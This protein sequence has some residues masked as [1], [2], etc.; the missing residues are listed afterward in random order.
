MRALDT[1][2]SPRLRGGDPDRVLRARLCV[3]AVP[4]A[5]APVVW[6]VAT[7]LAHGN[8]ALAAA[9]TAAGGLLAC[10]LPVL[11]F[12]GSLPLAGH[13]FTSVLFAYTVG[14]AWLSGGEALAALYGSALVPF[15]AVLFAGPRAGLA[16]GVAGAVSLLGLEVA[17]RGGAR[18][19]LA[20]DPAHAAAIRFRGAVWV[21]AAALL[22]AVLYEMLQRRA[23]ER[24]EA[25]RRY[26][27]ESERRYADLVENAP[28]GVL[29]CDRAGSI[30]LANPRLLQM[31]GSPGPDAT[32]RINVLTHPP[33]QRAGISGLLRRCMDEAEALQA[34]VTY[35]STWG[36]RLCARLHLGPVRAADGTVV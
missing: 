10:T 26:L 14:L 8:R 36:V 29:A 18:F 28:L 5:T 25:A 34:E 15:A 20:I 33:L 24:A 21:G 27:A 12:T 19:P 4:V 32:A 13:L 30:Q 16:W 6:S 22:G 17:V 11:R 3:A 9:S 31:L 2:L 7:A 35:D 23:L 1:W